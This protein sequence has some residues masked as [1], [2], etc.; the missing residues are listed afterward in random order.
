MMNKCIPSSCQSTHTPNYDCASTHR[1]VMPQ[2]TISQRENSR[3][4][5][6]EAFDGTLTIGGL[7][8]CVE[9]EGTLTTG[10]PPLEC[11]SPSGQIGGNCCS[12]FSDIGCCCAGCVDGNCWIP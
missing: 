10:E 3:R 7:A 9:F 12:P 11:W 4:L 2:V 6:C 5:F 8:L 1:N